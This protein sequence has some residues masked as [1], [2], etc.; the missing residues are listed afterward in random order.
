MKTKI[1]LLILLLTVVSFSVINAQLVILSGPEQASYHRFIED[2]N[3]VLGSSEGDAC[4]NQTTSGAEYN[5]NQLIDPKSPYK[6]AMVQ[7]DLLFF[8]QA[9]DMRENTE[10]TKDIKVI[11]PMANEEIHIVTKANSGLHKLQDLDSSLVAIGTKDQGTYATASLIKD[12]SKVYWSSRNIH[13][14]QALKDLAMDKIDAFFII[15]TA[16]IQKL[17]LDPRAMIIQP[18]LIE[19]SDLMAGQNIMITILFIP[20]IINGLKKIYQLLALK[21]F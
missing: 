12:R 13:F 18:A 5:F 11:L 21:L 8:K 10:K 14:E 19:L 9:L 15:G 16:P 17:D 2:I 20:K 1:S 3:N 4:V 6:V 7:S